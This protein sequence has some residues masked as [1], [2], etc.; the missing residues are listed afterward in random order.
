MAMSL[1]GQLED[2]KRS[3]A[4]KAM[5][6]KGQLSQPKVYLSLAESR[7]VGGGSVG[8]GRMFF[9]HMAQGWWGKISPSL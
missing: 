8:E 3:Q 6:W 7:Y 2:Q 9:H 4:F 1:A 5:T